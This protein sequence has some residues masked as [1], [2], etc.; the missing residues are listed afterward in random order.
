MEAK[1][2]DDV[3]MQPAGFGIIGILTDYVKKLRKIV[4]HM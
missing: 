3:N 4:G 1:P 2:E